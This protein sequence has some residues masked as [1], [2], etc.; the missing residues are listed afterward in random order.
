MNQ[1]SVEKLKKRIKTLEDQNKKLKESEKSL[2]EIEEKY[3]SMVESLPDGILTADSKGYVTFC[4]SAFQK[5][6]GF[7]KEEI[8]GLHVTKLST[9]H[10]KNIPEYIKLFGT[11]INNSTPRFIEFPWIKKQK[12]E[13]LGKAYISPLKK[14]KKIFGFQAILKDVTEQRKT[15]EELNLQT[16]YFEQLFKNSPDAIV[17]LDNSDKIIRANR[18]FEKLFHYSLKELVGKNIDELIVPE[19]LKDEA[20]SLSVSQSGKKV[21]KKE[22]VRKRKNGS[23]VNVSL[24]GF[25]IFLNN[26]LIGVY[27]AYSD[28][29]ERKE[30]EAAL[31]SSEER[32]R[33]IFEGSRDAIFITDKEGKFVDVNWAAATLTG[34]SKEELKDMVIP[35]L[36]ALEDLFA[37]KNFFH[38]IMAGEPITSKAK[39]L[40]KDGSKIVAEFSNRK[41]VINDVPYMHTVARDVTERKK[42]EKDLHLMKFSIDHS[43][44]ANLWIQNNGQLLYVNNAACRMLGYSRDELLSMK[45]FDFDLNYSE[46]N[47]PQ[48]WENLKKQESVVVESS[49]RKK[50][51][52]VIPVEI[53]AN[54]FN[55]N[56]EEYN[57]A[58]VR[59]ISHRKRAEAE[60]KKLEE[61]LF[62]SQKMESIGRLA[63]G[64]AHDFNN[65]LTGIMGYAELLKLKYQTTGTT[66]GMAAEV[67]FKNTER[68]AHLTKQLLG[69]ARKGKYNPLPLNL[70][71]MVKETLIVSDKI[72][73]KNIKVTFNFEKDIFP[74]DADKIQIEQ[75]ITNIIINAKD[76]MPAGGKLIFS[77][78]NIFV[79]EDKSDMFPELKPGRYV[80]LSITDTGI[81]IPEEIK[82]NIFEPFFTTKG[83]KN[84][85]GLGLATVYGIIK[86][87][88][89][90]I[91][92]ESEQTKGTTFT[93][94]LPASDK[95]FSDE[96]KKPVKPQ[97]G[98]G[99]ILV[100][101][102]E[103]NVRTL[104]QQQLN[105]LGYDVILAEDAIE[106][107]KIYKKEHENIDLVL[108][109]MIMP[110]LSGKEAYYELKNINPDIRV[111]V[112]S[113]YSQNEKALEIL[114]DGALDFIQKPYGIERLSTVIRDVLK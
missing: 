15:E 72:F 75:V 20:Y 113:G 1:Q 4:N 23:L 34:Y 86:N 60:R 80:K 35:D 90:Y 46:E 48:R 108:L 112:M 37:F 94:I 47:W 50:D 27:A 25:P 93:I 54:Y 70:N 12:E 85:T 42:A 44:E 39:I 26:K 83:M 38:R 84:G 41:I 52:S 58:F 6:T 57:F 24:A 74:V 21:F 88:D 33:M 73:E 55:F 71:E 31:R 11:L 36:H 13:R 101:D 16:T 96:R 68:A 92:C 64:I 106:G 103:E 102:D 79:Y 110:K 10:K 17:I 61:Q 104:A 56:G 28:I 63:G 32:F 5:L 76:A 8:E 62:Q 53:A 40:R 69:F 81:G 91:Y 3:H 66:E 105:S 2:R 14:G 87:H 114:N 109:D 107:I 7:S 18:A 100:I 89:G 29:S 51:G 49:Y 9:I 98:H 19:H 111:L 97:K 43:V 78:E 77:T 65:I 95:K 67:I 22:T 30:A 59:D 82:T 99:K 45:L